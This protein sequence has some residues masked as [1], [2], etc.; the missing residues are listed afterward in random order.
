MLNT[1]GS[2]IMR[3][4]FFCILTPLALVMRLFGYDPLKVKSNQAMSQWSKRKSVKFD[5]AFFNK[6]G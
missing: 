4:V 5:K 1:L 3:I 6:Q 2:F